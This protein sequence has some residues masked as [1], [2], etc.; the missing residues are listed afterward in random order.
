AFEGFVLAAEALVEQRG[1]IV[2]GRECGGRHKRRVSCNFK[3]ACRAAPPW[4]GFNSGPGFMHCR[5]GVVPKRRPSGGDPRTARSH[6]K[7]RVPAPVVSGTPYAL[8]K[9]RAVQWG[10]PPAGH[11]A[12]SLR[13]EKRASAG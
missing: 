6:A 5:R 11:R 8:A 9:G 1:K 2:A 10:S 4:R 12:P 3:F 13:G 7:K